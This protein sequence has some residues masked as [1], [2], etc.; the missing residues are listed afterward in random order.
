MKSAVFTFGRFNPP[1][2]GHEKLLIATGQIAKKRNAK[3]F[4]FASHKQDQKKDPLS[5]KDKVMFMKKAFPKF[6]NDIS[7]SESVKSALDACSFIY[8]KG[9]KHSTMVVV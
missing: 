2:I 7:N 8:S 5:W 9:Y 3:V 6:K 4:I 1:T